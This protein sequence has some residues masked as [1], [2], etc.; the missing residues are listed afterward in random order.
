MRIPS[1]G[2]LVREERPT[3]RI[4]TPSR[5]GREP[6]PSDIRPL[7]LLLLDRRGRG[8]SPSGSEASNSVDDRIEVR[9]DKDSRRPI[10]DWVRIGCSKPKEPW[11]QMN[12]NGAANHEMG[13]ILRR[14]I[15]VPV[16]TTEGAP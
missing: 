10:D 9:I 6:S 2:G 11:C 4:D 7:S 12:D 16:A 15:T 3:D 8:A 14:T 1:V 13:M 5:P